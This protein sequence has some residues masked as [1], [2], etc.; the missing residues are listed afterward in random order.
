MNRYFGLHTLEGE[1]HATLPRYL[2]VAERAAG[3]KVLDIGAGSGLGASLLME[4]GAA[5]V[6]AIDH[7]PA[8]VELARMKHG[9]QGLD[10]HV[11]FWEELG[12]AD[13]TFD[14]VLCLDPSSP[15]TDPN[16]LREVRRV[17][18]PGGEYV[19]AIER[20]NVRGFEA[21]L[22]RYGYTNVAEEVEL[23][24]AV[25]RVPQIGEL[26]RQFRRVWTVVQ[27]PQ[28][29]YVF[30]LERGQ[31]FDEGQAPEQARR[32]GAEDGLWVQESS[33]V[34]EGG[35]L[36]EFA[37]QERWISGDGRLTTASAEE[38]G[39]ELWCCGDEQM[40][41]PTLREVRMP[42]Y[43]LVA[44]LQA[45]L[46]ETQG[47]SSGRADLSGG[48]L[49]DEPH[50][51]EATNPK[52]A[53]AEL[54]TGTWSSV[55]RTEVFEEETTQVRMRRLDEAQRVS[56]QGAGVDRAELQLAQLDAHL[57]TLDGLQRRFK[58]DFDR[59][60]FEAQT[61][62]EAQQRSQGPLVALLERELEAAAALEEAQRRIAALEAELAGLRS[63]SAGVS[64][65]LEEASE[66]TPTVA[67]TAGSA[68]EELTNEVQESGAQG[69]P[70]PEEPAI[71]APDLD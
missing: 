48:L 62:L 1:W 22:P 9:K 4:L 28:L 53:L 19:C 41:A 20:K 36:H 45:V 54:R 47:T 2:F 39:V 60:L 31:S 21:V 14:L 15:V 30:D 23:H 69:S 56:A 6:D 40:V 18:K 32:V 24:E 57:G 71:T 8:V 43:D 38:G 59:V 44:R 68:G 66:A 11:M 63:L 13:Q 12:F 17:L 51:E 55:D 7:R 70:D 33:R 61:R 27:R 49:E 37:P 58:A 65:A 42:Y 5:Q 35:A 46:R 3:R 16:L 64:A 52:I 10:F 26:A 25:R 34:G 50:R 67:F 29:S